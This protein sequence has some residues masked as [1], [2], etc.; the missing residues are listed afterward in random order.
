MFIAAMN[1]KSLTFY[2]TSVGKKIVCA[3]TGF[4]LFG[5]VIVHLI[6]N[7]QIFRGPTELNDYAELL[8]S[9][10]GGLWTFRVLI[11]IA[12]SMHI[13][14]ALSVTVQNLKSRSLGYRF[15]RF[16]ETSIA[17]RTM[18]IGGPLLFLFVLSHLSHLTFG[19]AHSSFSNNVYNNVVLGFQV[20]WISLL[21]VAA[22]VLLGLHLSHGLWSMFQ[23]L[24]LFHPAFER[25]AKNSAVFVGIAV[26]F[27]N[28]A[29]PIAVLLGYLKPV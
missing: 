12:V 8:H 23:S 22:M 9:F 7:L 6:G 17:A 21:Y 4:I 1:L 25:F 13:V 16:R 19:I 3:V 28:S 27:C 29:V 10:G 20:K 5:F 18:W 24:G 2:Q 14:S 11:L 26:A 15:L